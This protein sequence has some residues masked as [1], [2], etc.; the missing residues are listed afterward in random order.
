MF[1]EDGDEPKPKGYEVKKNT[2]PAPSKTQMIRKKTVG[3]QVSLARLFFSSV[4]NLK[5]LDFLKLL[6]FRE[7]LNNLMTA[8]NSTTPHYVRCIKP[9]DLKAPFK[10]DI[11]LINFFFFLLFFFWATLLGLFLYYVFVLFETY[12]KREEK[13]KKLILIS[14]FVLFFLVLFFKGIQILQQQKI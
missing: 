8:L 7:S 6:K 5:N 9:N 2:M 4:S 10:W 3:S 1:T 11:F 13:P 12:C 14:L